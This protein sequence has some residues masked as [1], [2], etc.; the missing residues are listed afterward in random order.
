M[1]ALQISN[2]ILIIATDDFAYFVAGRAAGFIT[3]GPSGWA[4]D[5]LATSHEIRGVDTARAR[6][7]DRHPGKSSG[8]ACA[9]EVGDS[10]FI[11]A[12]DDVAPFC[13]LGTAS[14]PREGNAI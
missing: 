13:A 1:G 7:I 3:E 4:G 2:S 14:L 5:G 12:A 6:V 8:E 9:F 10:A 11:S